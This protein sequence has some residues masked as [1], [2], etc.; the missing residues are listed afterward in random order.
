MTTVFTLGHS[1]RSF[2][3]VLEMLRAESVGQLVDVRRFPGSRTH[4]Q[5]NQQSIVG[6]LPLDVAYTWIAELG[7]RRYTPVGTE[8]QN[9]WWRVKAFRDY[10]DHLQSEEFARGLTELVSLANERVTAIMCS[11]AVPWRCHRRLIA[12]ALLV[13]GVEVHH[14]IASRRTEPAVLT[15]AVRI[16]DGHLMY[17]P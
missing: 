5:W 13:Q 4:P 15:P 3:K 16:R 7:G 1:D 17:P 10:A 6:A 11:E 8:T 12:D 2:D 9:G 14:L